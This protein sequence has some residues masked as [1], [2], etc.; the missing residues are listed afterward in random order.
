MDKR[1]QDC[2]GCPKMRNSWSLP[3]VSPQR[4][5]LTPRESEAQPKAAST[6]N[7]KFH[8]SLFCFLIS[9]LFGS[10]LFRHSIVDVQCPVS[11]RYTTSWFH[12]SALCCAHLRC[13]HRLSPCSAVTVP[14]TTFAMLY[15]WFL[16]L[17]R[18]LNGSLHLPLPFTHFV[19]PP[20][21]LPSGSHQS[22]LLGLF[23]LLCFVLFFRL[24]TSIESNSIC[25]SLT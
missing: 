2:D 16:G 25:L 22:V 4:E 19:P 11:L 15:L 23:L 12:S 24:H 20:T 13:G 17:C 7:A 1:T 8:W 10:V 3:A 6:P 14:R 21:P 18:S 5:S 9:F